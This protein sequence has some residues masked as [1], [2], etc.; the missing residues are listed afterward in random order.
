MFGSDDQ[1]STLE[2]N[3][4]PLKQTDQLPVSTSRADERSDWPAAGRTLRPATVVAMLITRRRS[5][6]RLAEQMS[7]GFT[8]T[9]EAA[10]ATASLVKARP[11]FRPRPLGV[12]GVSYADVF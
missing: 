4:Q 2:L 12:G 1:L 3:N 7:E 5:V 8:R 11:V 6:E 10:A 9:S